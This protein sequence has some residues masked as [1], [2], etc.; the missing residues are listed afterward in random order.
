M[1]IELVDGP[2]AEEGRVQITRNGVKGTVCDDNFDN[3]A[4]TVVCRMLGYRLEQH[5]STLDLDLF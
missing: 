4:A 1:T 3:N 5:I 2:S